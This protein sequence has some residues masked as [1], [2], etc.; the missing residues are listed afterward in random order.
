MHLSLNFNGRQCH[1]GFNRDVGD[2][3]VEEKYSRKQVYFSAV[4]SLPRSSFLELGCQLSWRT[5]KTV[6]SSVDARLDVVEGEPV[7]Q[8]SNRFTNL[9]SVLE[10]INAEDKFLFN[11]R[12]ALKSLIKM[13]L[14]KLIVAVS[15]GPHTCTW[16]FA[17]GKEGVYCYRQHVDSARRQL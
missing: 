1:G 17:H 14:D 10:L 15:K 2:S 12:D 8:R 11:F 9:R 16:R 3:S 4:V 13:D 7:P 5:P 6:Q